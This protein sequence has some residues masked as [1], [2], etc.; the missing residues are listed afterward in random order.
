MNPP[1][2]ARVRRGGSAALLAAVA[3]IAGG[4]GPPGPPGLPAL[5]PAPAP[6]PA[7]NLTPNP[8]PAPDPNSPRATSPSGPNAAGSIL[9][10]NERPIDLGTALR[11]AG[12]Q[13]P[14][15][16]AGPSAGAGGGRGAAVRGGADPADAQRRHELRH[17][18]RQLA[19]VERQHPLDEPEAL[20]VG[21]GAFAVAAGHGQRSR[22]SRWPGTSRE[23][24]ISTWRAGRS[25]GSG[26]WP[27]PRSRTRPCSGRRWRTASCSAPRGTRAIAEQIRDQ[28]AEVARI[29]AAYARTGEGRQ[30][31]ADRAATELARR[32]AD[33]RQAE[34]RMLEASARLCR[35]LNLDPSIRLHP[36]D[37][38]VVP[39]P[40]IPD[41]VPLCELIAIALMRRPE[42][43]E[44]RA[45]I[46]QALLALEGAKVLPFSPTVL[47][48]LQ[49]RRVRRRQ[50]PG[51][52]RLRQLRHPGRLRRDRL[53][54]APQPRRR[55]PRA[56]QHRQGPPQGDPVTRSWP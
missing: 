45:V 41:P 52:A 12:A 23:G 54:V 28:A 17:P 36:T 29:T 44:R 18:H 46:R 1:R 30:A 13:N 55:Q 14:A 37:A 16:P 22:A 47:H 26:N 24:S 5:Y 20:Y 25:S 8:N 32:R 11:L 31:D 56:D 21:G 33:V 19:A 3:L 39:M 49:R 50:Q 6:A 27:A 53:L 40:V 15:A 51:P 10:P 4:A 42:L 2:L 43:G 9:E 7:P 35:V 38:Y 48:R 34:G